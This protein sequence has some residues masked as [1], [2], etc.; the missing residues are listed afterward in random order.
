MG[1]LEG[2]DLAQ[3][4]HRVAQDSGPAWWLAARADAAEAIVQGALPDKRDDE[5]WGASPKRFFDVDWSSRDAGPVERVSTWRDLAQWVFVDGKH[6]ASEHST[7]PDGVTVRT[8][9]E[10]FRSNEDLASSLNSTRHHDGCPV[11]A[12]SLALHEDGLWVDIAE[13][14]QLEQP[15]VI[16]HASSASVGAAGL[17]VVVNLGAGASAR[18]VE[19]W[20]GDSAELSIAMTEAVLA[21]NARLE[22]VKFDMHGEQAKHVQT[23]R[24]TLAAGAVLDATSMGIGSRL[25][26]TELR[27]RL[28]GKDARA[29]LKGL[30]LGCRDQIQDHYVWVDHEVPDCQSYQTFRSLVAD[31]AR[32]LFTGR[33]VVHPDAQRTHAEQQHDSLLLSDGAVANARPQ[34]EIYADDV[35][36]RHGATVGQMDTEALFYLRQRGLSMEEA[37]QLLLSAFTG[38]VFDDLPDDGIR[39]LLSEAAEGWLSVRGADA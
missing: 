33:V 4:P 23:L 27:I 7:L 10:A 14:V 25:S 35:S 30:T 1:S 11:D 20:C 16:V 29:D 36:C 5:W 37:R 26:R 22:W 28:M 2:K 8:F 15:L 18:L 6:H 21:E 34:L 12:A 32:G 17:R 9:R 19:H 3:I 24:G 31:R 38:A 39:N 13:G